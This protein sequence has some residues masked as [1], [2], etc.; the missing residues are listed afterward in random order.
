[1]SET[2]KFYSPFPWNQHIPTFTHTIK[3]P[4]IPGITTMLLTTKITRPVARQFLARMSSTHVESSVLF[5]NKN[6]ARLITLNR[7]NKLNSLNTEMIDLITPRLWEYSKSSS[8][9]VVVLNS[10]S[11]KALCAGGDVAECAKQTL[12]GNVEYS[13]TFFQKEYNLNYLIS[14][15]SKPYVAIMDGITFG[16][17]V[18]LSVHAPFRVATERTKLAMPEMD[19]GFFPDVGTTFFLPRL[20]DKLGYYYAM[21]GDMLTGLDAYM[22]GFATHY[23]RSEKIDHVINRLSNLQPPVINDSKTVAS[24]VIHSSG[25]Y[26]AQ[27]NQAIEEFSENELPKDYKFP[28][29]TEQLTL[30]NSA[31]SQPSVDEIFQYLEKDGSEFAKTTLAKLAAKPMSSLKVAYELMNRGAEN[32]IKQQFELELV[33]ATN[34]MNQEVSENDFVR[35]VSHKLINKIKDPA[36]PEWKPAGDITDEFVKSVTSKSIKTAKLPTPL[37]NR[38]FNIDFKQYPHHMGLPNN[39]QVSAY[40]VGNDGSN[41]TYLPTPSEVVKHFKRV[42]GKLGV[43][44]TV[45][46]ILDLHGDGE[47]YDGKYM[48]WK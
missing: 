11:P 37:I 1:V 14:T 6:G 35:G 18:G 9:N 28:L 12:A 33:A 41:R 13:T 27:V 44:Q 45:E 20:D 21:T 7:L 42:N 2:V 19:I 31:F 29:N 17:G 16:G 3:L 24:E 25:E 34:I 32:T 4:N 39:Q 46:R 47:K 5:S 36:Y 10:N 48:G 40:I 22:V 15:Y 26:F 30:I 43:E 38:Y 23:V 8:N